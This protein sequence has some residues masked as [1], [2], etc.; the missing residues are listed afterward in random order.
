ME[1][2]STLCFIV[3]KRSVLIGHVKEDLDGNLQSKLNYRTLFSA[4]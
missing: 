2:F 3:K 1:T 4:I